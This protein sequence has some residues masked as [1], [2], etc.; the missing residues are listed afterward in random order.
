[1]ANSPNMVGAGL[2]GAATLLIAGCSP[3][4]SRD[5]PPGATKSRELKQVTLYLPGMNQQLQIL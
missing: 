5:N 4:A 2:I 3:P 1:M